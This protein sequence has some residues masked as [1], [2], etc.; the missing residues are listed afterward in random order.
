MP[1]PSVGYTPVAVDYNVQI[2]GP[3]NA[4]VTISTQSFGDPAW[5]DALPAAVS[6]FRDSL[7]AT[8]CDVAVYEVAAGT[9]E[10][11]LH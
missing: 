6:A 11:Q 8:G 9:I 1:F 4:S 10:R 2:S 5:E 7:I 3:M